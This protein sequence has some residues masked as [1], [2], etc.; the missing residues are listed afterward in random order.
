MT[1][2]DENLFPGNGFA[3]NWQG[4]IICGE[5]KLFVPRLSGQCFCSR[6]HPLLWHR[7]LVST[8]SRSPY[9]SSLSLSVMC[10]CMLAAVW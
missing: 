3:W 9:V 5:V 1:N 6:F 2:D 7:P 8:C 4:L 10:A